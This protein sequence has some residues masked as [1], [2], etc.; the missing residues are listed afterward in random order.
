[1]GQCA[2][3]NKRFNLFL[4]SVASSQLRLSGVVISTFLTEAL[5]L[6]Q[7]YFHASFFLALIASD[8]SMTISVAFLSSL[9]KMSLFVWHI[10]LRC[11]LTPQSIM[12]FLLEGLANGYY[13]LTPK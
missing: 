13:C 10:N 6:K 4:E 12:E 2:Q 3:R 7:Y 9:N 8:C 5:C 1:M 11:P